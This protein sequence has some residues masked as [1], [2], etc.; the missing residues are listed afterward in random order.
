MK[1]YVTY[2]K[3]PEIRSLVNFAKLVCNP[4]SR[5]EAH[6]SIR[7]PYKHK[8]NNDILTKY[9]AI[10]SGSKILVSGIGSFINE[11]QNT[12]FLK[13]KSE[14]IKKVWTRKNKYGYNPHITIYDNSLKSFASSL[15]NELQKLSIRFSFTATKLELIEFGKKIFFNDDGNFSFFLN[16]HIDFELVKSIINIKFTKE[17]IINLSANE[18]I[19]IV[20]D[21][22]IYLNCDY[23]K[24][25]GRLAQL[26]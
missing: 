1:I 4:K 2:I 24:S 6:V 18:K 12:V 11:N 13:C 15:F 16:S 10:L 8:I 25:P 21:V 5:S 17:D 19:E 7:G 20:K 26:V 22:L 9:N 3:E 23:K 14:S